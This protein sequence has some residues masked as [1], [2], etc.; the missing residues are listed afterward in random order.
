MARLDDVVVA[1]EA[2]VLG[3]D[4]RHVFGL[5]D[6][7][8]GLCP[9]RGGPPPQILDLGLDLDQLKLDLAINRIGRAETF[10]PG[11]R[12]RASIGL[13]KRRHD[14]LAFRDQGIQLALRRHHVGMLFGVLRQQQPQLGLQFDDAVF[15]VVRR[16]GI[17]ELRRQGFGNALQLLTQQVPLGDRYA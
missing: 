2:L 14:R 12:G 17:D 1:I 3:F 5:A 7:G 9:G 10:V 4:P 16:A 6:Q 13:D 8:L 11:I 15:G